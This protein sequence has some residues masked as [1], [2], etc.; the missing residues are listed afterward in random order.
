M[1]KLKYLNNLMVVL[2]P[3]SFPQQNNGSTKVIMKK[4][5]V[6]GKPNVTLER[7]RFLRVSS[8]AFAII[9]LLDIW[10]EIAAHEDSSNGMNYL[11]GKKILF[12]II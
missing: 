7:Q 10:G 3:G 1:V 2:L 4:F 6:K 9:C 11:D 5:I 12:L 8:A